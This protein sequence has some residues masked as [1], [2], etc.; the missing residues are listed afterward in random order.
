MARTTRTNLKNRQK[1]A[2]CYRNGKCDDCLSDRQHKNRKREEESEA[3]E[4]SL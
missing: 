4:E 1:C 3:Q 2:E